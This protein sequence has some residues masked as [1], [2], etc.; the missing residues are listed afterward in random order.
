MESHFEGGSLHVTLAEEPSK[1]DP[2]RIVRVRGTWASGEIINAQVEDATDSFIPIYAEGPTDRPRISDIQEHDF[3]ETSK[4]LVSEVG[5]V[6]A[7]GGTTS[8][9]F[10]YVIQATEQLLAAL[11][12]SP[13]RCRA[14]IAVTPADA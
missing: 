14:F 8:F 9:F 2:H 1:T 12:R 5:P 4:S 13:F 6:I 3:M 11:E 10:V 7:A